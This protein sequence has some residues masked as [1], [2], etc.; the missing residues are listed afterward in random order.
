[1]KDALCWARD[2]G[3]GLHTLG[4]ICVIRTV[5]PGDLLWIFRRKTLAAFVIVIPWLRYGQADSEEGK[6]GAEN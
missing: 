1:M 6:S 3:M 5:G 2:E 4:F